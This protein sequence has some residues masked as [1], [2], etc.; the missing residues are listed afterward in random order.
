MTNRRRIQTYIKE[1]KIDEA[2]SLMRYMP[3]ETKLST[4]ATA[5]HSKRQ[6]T[7]ISERTKRRGN[8]D[9][10]LVAVWSQMN[11]ASRSTCS[12]SANEP[13]GRLS[14]RSSTLQITA[15]LN[16]HRAVSERLRSNI[17]AGYARI[18]FCSI[19]HIIE[20][21]WGQTKSVPRGNMV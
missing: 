10:W 5:R 17:S 8:R 1:P 21:R 19:N 14:V 6:V 20:R 3:N 2:S 9:A 4:K 11:L 18:I 16:A 13:Y 12:R 7:T 15:V